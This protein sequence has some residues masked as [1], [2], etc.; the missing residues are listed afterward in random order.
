MARDFTDYVAEIFGAGERVF[1]IE[2]YRQLKKDPEVTD[3]EFNGRKYLLN[4]DRAMKVKWAPWKKRTWAH[5]LDSLVET[6]RS[7]TVGLIVYRE[8]AQSQPEVEEVVTEVPEKYQCTIC[9]FSTEHERTAKAHVTKK[10]KGGKY[11]MV[12]KVLTKQVK[13][14]EVK[15]EVVEPYHISR[16]HQPS[17]RIR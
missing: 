4:K 14:F 9:P 13:H 17:G 12:M 6:F 16:M 10:H 2:H 3:F 11:E 8:P 15:Q 5:P 1:L 7:K